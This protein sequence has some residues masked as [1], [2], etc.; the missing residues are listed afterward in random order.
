MCVVFHNEN[1]FK[2]RYSDLPLFVVSLAKVSVTHGQL[3]SEGIKWK[4][5]DIN[6][7]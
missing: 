1:L 4:I 2:N 3:Q 5:P 7:S 6:S